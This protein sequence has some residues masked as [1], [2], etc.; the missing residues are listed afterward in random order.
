M[1]CTPIYQDGK[2]IGFVCSRGR[3]KTKA[4]VVCGDPSTKL[5][6]Y[7]LTGKRSGKTCDRPLCD[8][9]AV[10]QPSIRHID[11]QAVTFTET[12]PDDTFD[13]CPTHSRLTERKPKS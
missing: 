8:K 3:A 2:R 4:C 5:C 12:P 6:D 13:L 10:T 9:C 7:P 1:T 11:T